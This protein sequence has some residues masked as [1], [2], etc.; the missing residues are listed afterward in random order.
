[1]AEP[2]DEHFITTVS[3]MSGSAGE[4]AHDGCV[5][6]R[7]LADRW[8]V[9]GAVRGAARQPAPGPGR[10]L[11]AQLREARASTQSG[12]PDTKETPGWRPRSAPTNGVPALPLGRVLRRARAPGA[13]HDTAHGDVLL[14]IVASTDEPIAGGRHKVFGGRGSTVPRTSTIASQLPKAVGAAFFLDRAAPGCHAGGGGRN[15]V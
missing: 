14:G 15:R 10:P 13:G 8:A 2:I 1:M 7:F 3:A 5:A 11:A 4:R 6:R 9:P 12:G